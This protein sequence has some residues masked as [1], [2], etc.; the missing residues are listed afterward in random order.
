[1]APVQSAETTLPILE[2]GGAVLVVSL[3]LTLAWTL[4]LYR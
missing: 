2:V 4:Y 3:L 1:M